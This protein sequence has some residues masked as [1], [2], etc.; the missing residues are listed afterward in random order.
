MNLQFGAGLDGPEEWVNVDASPTLR[1]Q[2]LPLAGALFRRCLQPVFGARVVY[3]D[4]VRGLPFAN[5]SVALVYCSHVLEHLALEDFE[6]ALAEVHRLLKPGGVFRGVLPDLALEV[7][8]Y[9]D[10]NEA[11]RAS[12]FMRSTLL[13]TERRPRDVAGWI[14]EALGNSRHTWMWDQR[15]L[16]GRLEAAGFTAVRPAVYN[17]SE[18][19][20]FTQVEAADR[21]KGAMG[22]ECR[23][24]G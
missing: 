6:R 3:G 10:C 12:H 19:A 13:G 2:R 11:D 17:D 14:R 24:P 1:L 8:A 5:G 20:A 15:S 22:F 9:L 21:W 16:A 4:I 18:C 7:Q 23:K